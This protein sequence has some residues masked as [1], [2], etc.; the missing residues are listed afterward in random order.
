MEH[1]AKKEVRASKVG[2][3][4]ARDWKADLIEGGKEERQEQ[5]KVLLKENCNAPKKGRGEHVSAEGESDR[6]ITRKFFGEILNER[7]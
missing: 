6:T 1:A 2:K 3:T 5:K 4:V 7:A